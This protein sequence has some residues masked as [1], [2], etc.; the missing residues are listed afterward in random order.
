MPGRH[1]ALRLLTVAALLVAVPAVADAQKKPK[2]PPK[3]YTIP[4]PVSIT[5]KPNPTIFSTPVTVSGDVKDAKGGVVVRLQ[6][7]R[8][9]GGAFTTVATGTTNN[10]GKYSLIN[11]PSVNV[12]YRVQADTSPAQQSGEL[13]VKVRMLVG[14][15]VSDTTPAKGSRVKFS[16]IV[17]PPHN[18]RTAAIQRKSST[19]RWV[20]VARPRLRALDSKSSRYSKRIRVRRTA[21]Y[22]VRVIGHADHAMGISRERVLTTH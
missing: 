9:T 16:G 7:R 10:A 13:L 17:R 15:R 6:R 20:T 4:G 21:T 22:R 12:Y 1:T 11:R 19:G 8:S 5:A 14:F 2:K 18:G 3:P